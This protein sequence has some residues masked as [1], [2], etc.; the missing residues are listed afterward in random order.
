MKTKMNKVS[1]DLLLEKLGKLEEQV[2]LLK[3]ELKNVGALCNTLSEAQQN[4]TD[5]EIKTDD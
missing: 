5:I 1:F 4:D 2:K 3:T